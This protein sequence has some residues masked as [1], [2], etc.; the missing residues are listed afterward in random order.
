M[1]YLGFIFLRN[2]IVLIFFILFNYII[3][4]VY[5]FCISMEGIKEFK[6][7]SSIYKVLG[8]E[9]FVYIIVFVV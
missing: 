3:L 7:L 8:M 9:L 6:Y 5:L 1:I 2:L 4:F